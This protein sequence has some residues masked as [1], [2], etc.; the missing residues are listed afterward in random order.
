MVLSG[1][2][3]SRMGR[4]KGLLKN[5][6]LFWA[7]RIERL[8]RPYVSRVVF[9]LNPNQEDAYRRIPGEIEI[10]G[11]RTPVRGPLNGI[12][13]VHRRYSELD[14]LVVAVDLQNLQTVVLDRLLKHYA[15]NPAADFLVFRG[16]G[17]RLEPLCAIYRARGL[18]RLSPE[19]IAAS[20]NYRLSSL[21]TTSESLILE[22]PADLEI[23]LRNFNTPEDRLSD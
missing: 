13:S 16:P 2:A 11:D 19:K 12:L 9:S 6:G 1:G 3:S 4:D 17:G 15:S 23:F 10:I 14:L 18:A 5:E 22:L 7:E 20:G 21:F 8:L